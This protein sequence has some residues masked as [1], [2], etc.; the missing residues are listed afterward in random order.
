MPIYS[1]KIIATSDKIAPR[2]TQRVDDIARY[3]MSYEYKVVGNEGPDL[4]SLKDNRL[5]NFALFMQQVNKIDG[6]VERN[7]LGTN[8]N[9]NMDTR[10]T[11]KLSYKTKTDVYEFECVLIDEYW[12]LMSHPDGTKYYRLLSLF[13]VSTTSNRRAYFDS[14]SLSTHYKFSEGGLRSLVP[15]W[16]QLYKGSM[17]KGLSIIGAETLGVGGIVA[18]YS[19]KSSYEKLM[20]EDPR[21]MKEYSILADTWT[22]IGYGCIAF[23]AA[24]YIYNLIDATVAPG[25]R[26][27]IV[28]S[29]H[30]NFSLYPAAMNNTIGIAGVYKF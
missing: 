5:I 21:H 26:R 23:A 4:Q 22:N 11:H 27:V 19:M 7:T 3:D 28:K 15:G 12:C 13:A 9:G 17:A 16:G 18:S 6:E 29:N 8:L 10:T 20:Q 25:A 1:Q 2:W 24:V 30:P 14:Y